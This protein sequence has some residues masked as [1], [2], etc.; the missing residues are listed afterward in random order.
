MENLKKY[1]YRFGHAVKN[2]LLLPDYVPKLSMSLH[3][4]IIYTHA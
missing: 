2:Y 3:I 1:E 4:I